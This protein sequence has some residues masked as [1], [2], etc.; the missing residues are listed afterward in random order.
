MNSEQPAFEAINS[1]EYTA[2]AV[3]HKNP[4]LYADVTDLFMVI[5]PQ[6]YLDDVFSAPEP[7][8]SMNAY[9]QL[10]TGEWDEEL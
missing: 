9:E 6:D 1:G 10:V 7:D 5:D 2:A 4:S 8:R 3:A